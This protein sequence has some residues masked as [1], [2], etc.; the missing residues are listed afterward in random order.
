MTEDEIAAL[1]ADWL[2]ATP[3]ERA[4]YAFAR[5]FTFEPHRLSDADLDGLR[6]FY[7]DVQILEMILSMAG[8]NQINRW[9]D[10]VGVPQSANGGGFGRRGGEAKVEKKEE[11]QTYLT[12]TSTGS[13]SSTRTCRSWR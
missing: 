5:K 3:A 2:T 1:D 11:K 4:A 9:K 8:N 6:K 10:G 7:K 12:P 13:A